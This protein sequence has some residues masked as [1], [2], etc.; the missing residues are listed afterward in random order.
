MLLLIK[1]LNRIRILH[2]ILSLHGLNIR[3]LIRTFLS[4]PR[5]LL[6]LREFIKLSR[7]SKMS[8]KQKLLLSPVLL[9][10]NEKA[11]AYQSEYFLQD[12][13]VANWIYKLKNKNK[14]IDIG[15][16]IDGFISNVASFSE[17]FVADVREI[18]IPFKNITSIKLDFTKEIPNHL[19][20][21]FDVVTSLHALEHFGLGRYSDE[22]DPNGVF[23]GL[24]NISKLVKE[25][26]N[27]CISLPYG[28]DIIYFNERRTFK[29]LTITKMAENLQLKTKKII[30]LN[31]YGNFVSEEDNDV[32]LAIYF[33]EK[34]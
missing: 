19:L 11:G 12:L 4:I 26:G 32:S 15:S 27:I 20:S 18:N 28:E 21:Q 22:L 7:N 30:F 33:M 17:I 3:K 31:P 13:Y 14:I 6:D 23:K 9:D 29:S 8:Y 16:R 25:D 24:R 5:Y 34:N 2:N 1:A 10:F